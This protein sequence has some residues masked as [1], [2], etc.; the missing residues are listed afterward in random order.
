MV[1]WALL[2]NNWITNYGYYLCCLGDHNISQAASVCWGDSFAASKWRDSACS[3]MFKEGAYEQCAKCFA[4]AGLAL[5]PSWR[6][7]HST[8]TS[9]FKF[10]SFKLLLWCYTWLN[11]CMRMLM[12]PF[13]RCHCI[14]KYITMYS[15]W[16]WLRKD[17]VF[18]LKI[19]KRYQ[20]SQ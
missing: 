5:W 7:T 8:Q 6:T 1:Y 15:N 18:I 9:L 19:K 3:C 4:G 2:N 20:T 12:L 10:D 17:W 13:C 16:I 11:S 14:H